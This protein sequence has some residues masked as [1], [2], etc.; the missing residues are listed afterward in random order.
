VNVAHALQLT[1]DC[2]AVV[3]AMGPG[4]LG[5]DSALGFSGLEVA[6]IL[7]LGALGRESIV[8]LRWSDADER[9]RHRG[10]SHHS[11]MALK[12]TPEPVVVPVPEGSPRPKVG[13]HDVVEVDVPDVGALFQEAGLDVRT[14][15]RAPA[16][17]PGFFAYAAAAGVVA[18]Q[19]V[20]R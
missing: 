15:G 3:V 14:M 20:E 6:S 7:G 19:R 16:E 4:S 13:D 5:T 9:E 12:L 17:D 2:D 18:A 1:I 8:A 11:V 10:L